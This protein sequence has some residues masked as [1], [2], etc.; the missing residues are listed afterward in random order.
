ML[1][2]LHVVVAPQEHPKRL[3]G[4]AYGDSSYMIT[5]KQIVIVV[6]LIAG[7]TFAVPAAAMEG[8]S[9]IAISVAPINPDFLAYQ[10]TAEE[11]VLASSEEGGERPPGLIPP[12]LDL[13]HIGTS[14]SRPAPMLMRE[15]LPVAY[16]L[17]SQ[18]RVTPVKDQGRVGSCWAFS[19]IASL[20]S[21]LLPGETRD[22]AENHMKNLCSRS[23]PEGFDRAD[24][25]GGN[26]HIA[27]AYL[28]R[29]TGPVNEEDDPYDDMSGVSPTDLAPE[30]HVQDVLFLP[31]LTG[32]N[33]V[34]MLKRAIMEHGAVYT[35][36]HIQK[37]YPY[38]NPRTASYYYDGME[39]PNHGVTVVGWNDTY[40]RNQFASTPPMD[41]AWIIKN[42]W[43]TDFGDG[44]YFYLSYCD[45]AMG[46]RN[47]VFTG[48]DVDNYDAV[49]QHDPLGWVNSFG[50]RSETGWFATVFTA[51]SDEEIRAV[52][53]YT[54]QYNSPYK[55]YVY[56]DPIAGP[57]NASGPVA[58]QTGTIDDA[59]YCT[60]PLED[61]VNL[62][63]GQKF[64]VVM[65]V[66]TP[67]YEYPIPVEY[68][69]TGYSS[70]ATAG[71]GEGYVRIGEEW[72]DLTDLVKNANPCLKAFTVVHKD[73]PSVTGI[74][75]DHGYQN[76][77]VQITNLSGTGF[78]DG[79]AVRLTQAGQ[80]D[81]TAT[82]VS[83]LSPSQ[84]TCTLD[85]T[86]SAAGLRDV[87][88]ENP[89]GQTAALQQGFTIDTPVSLALTADK[90]VVVRGNR[91][92]VTI[93]GEAKKDYRIFVRNV[94]GVS[95]RGY[96]VVAPDQADIRDYSP[97]DVTVT[98]TATGTRPIQF[99]TNQSTADVRFTI[100]V[101]DP[102]DPATFD[103]VRVQVVR[104]D[105]TIV[106]AGT[107]VYSIGEEIFLSG[108]N[109]ESAI[110]YLFVTGPGLAANGSKLDDLAVASITRDADT[111]T[112]A[113]VELDDTWAYRWD[114]GAY[115][116]LPDCGTYTIYAVALP[117][118]R[119]D[120]ANT[121]YGTTSVT[122]RDE[123][124][125]VANFTANV[126]TGITPLTVEFT[127]ASTGNPVNWSW[128]FGDG[129]TSAEQHPT[130]T[131]STPGNYTV[132]LSVD[133]GL[134]T[135]TKP[136]Y[137]KVTPVLFGDADGDGKVN[138]AD[139]LLVLQEVVGLVE[140]EEMPR[141]GTD[142]FQR[143]DVNRNG[144]IEVGDALFIAQY[145]VG[146]RDVWF[147]LL[148]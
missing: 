104:G 44:G 40:D 121:V 36:M 93:T 11:N 102:A 141:P 99:D 22:F 30:V 12:P 98:T 131:Y 96:P 122:L 117:N 115:G 75:P 54:A 55:L 26:H 28:A 74:V 143:T 31:D 119:N 72:K 145:N 147:E 3:Y 88:V 18:G 97:T 21:S 79:A 71:P 81:I 35:S 78:W 57:I 100:R 112:R 113:D 70:K 48:E 53:L 13:S 59:G 27:T 17:R 85:L 77:I 126:T 142:R 138:Q 140:N 127:D 139:T 86:G 108:T 2:Y 6:A 109:T 89:D 16:D 47:T 106:A 76:Q 148:G 39:K 65:S 52:S 67:G 32:P 146:L 125:L 73:P 56:L 43:G 38:Y 130:H 134:S 128:I 7:I 14:E 5:R 20:E 62:S 23:Y 90:D 64:S 34:A 101:E 124:E 87:V 8:Q 132:A 111:F 24:T 58:F 95:P 61:P 135:A 133:D 105:V 94:S 107:G 33:E 80:P 46:T 37:S 83:V 10:K 49:Y 41:G 68:P 123:P 114:T 19:A 25:E 120:L 66:T 91:F 4:T 60:I 137:I 92:V 118:A 116:L 136:D 45:S 144:V 63:A 15:A 82:G 51:D 29:W 84:I 110:T 1:K 129:G 103:E 50:T 42:S 9:S 69:V